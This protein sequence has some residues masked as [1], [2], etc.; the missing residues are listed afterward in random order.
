MTIPARLHFCWIGPS[1]PWVYVFAILSAADR[2]EIDDIVLHHT[3]RLAEDDRLDALRRAPGVRLSRIDADDYLRRT[4]DRLGLGEALAELYA[5]LDRPV[6]RAD[7]LRSAILYSEGGVYLDLDTVTVASLLPLLGAETFV[8]S[9]SI[10]WP[11]RVRR[12]RSPVLW[13]RHLALDVVR[14]VLSGMPH[15]WKAFRLVERFYAKSVN[16]AV[17]GAVRHSAFFAD[18]LREMVAGRPDLGS[19]Y[20]LGPHLLQR[21]VARHSGDGLVVHVPSVFYPLAPEISRHWFRI[22]TRASLAGL[23]SADTRIVHWYASVRTAGLARMTPDDVRRNRHRQLYSALVCCCIDPLPAGTGPDAS[24]PD[25]RLPEHPD[26][27]TEG[28]AASPSI[29]S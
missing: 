2:S 15:G 25:A 11:D 23:L 3:D 9:E 7:V 5:A 6:M 21:M 17:M 28:L 24:H 4:A 13:A 22:G 14:K 19:R 8:G 18:M 20:A 29:E 27:P 1:L 12:S 26:L 16:N 10:V